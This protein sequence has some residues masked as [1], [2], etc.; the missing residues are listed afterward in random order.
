MPNEGQFDEALDYYAWI[1]HELSHWTGHGTRLDRK[2]GRQGVFGTDAYAQAELRAEMAAMML[3]IRLGVGHNP[4]HSASYIDG[5]SPRFQ[6]RPEEIMRASQAAWEIV[7]MLWKL[8]GLPADPLESAVGPA[9]APAAVAAAE[10]AF[11]LA[12][13]P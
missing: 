8:S 1:L 2:A 6:N 5:G 11:T 4:K 10:T 7:D 9:E 13:G 3:G 12:T